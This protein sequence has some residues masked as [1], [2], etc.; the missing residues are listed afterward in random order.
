MRLSTKGK[1][2][3]LHQFVRKVRNKKGEILHYPKVKG[4]RNHDN[5]LHWE[6]Q[7]TWR[8]KVDGVVK[9]HCIRVLPTKATKIKEL[10][11]KGVDITE[12]QRFLK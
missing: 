2:G 12:I 7:L 3:S 6:Y 1:S 11:V 10:I 4:E 5:P 9:S 8:E